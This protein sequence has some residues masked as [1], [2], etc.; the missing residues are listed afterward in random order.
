MVLNSETQQIRNG[1]K[2]VLN[3]KLNYQKLNIH[4]EYI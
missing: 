1:L 4:V 3:F 2:N